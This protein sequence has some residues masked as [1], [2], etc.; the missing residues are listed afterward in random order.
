MSDMPNEIRD[1]QFAFVSAYVRWLD[2]TV[3]DAAIS[4]YLTEIETMSQALRSLDKPDAAHTEPFTAEW[5]D[6]ERA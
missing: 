2:P 4:R 6:G 1:A 3:T 5:P